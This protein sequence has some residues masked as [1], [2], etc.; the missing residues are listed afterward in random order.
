[1]EWTETIVTAVLSKTSSM[2][3][4]GSIH[5][6]ISA[7]DKSPVVMTPTFEEGGA[8][9]RSHHVFADGRTTQV[10]SRYVLDGGATYMVHNQIFIEGELKA[11]AR[12]YFKRS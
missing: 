5:Q 7:V 11:E 6:E 3:V 12:S 8:C 1:M 10:I 2:T 4:D 9:V